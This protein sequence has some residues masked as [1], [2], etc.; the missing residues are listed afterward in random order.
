MASRHKRAHVHVRGLK[1]KIVLSKRGDRES[2]GE[3]I[4]YGRARLKRVRKKKTPKRK[5]AQ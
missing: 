4:D 5:E 2:Y 3:V 1:L